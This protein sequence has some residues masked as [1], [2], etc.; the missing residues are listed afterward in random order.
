MPRE[1]DSRPPARFVGGHFALDFLNTAATPGGV[2]VEWL[3]N[4]AD[5]VEWMEQAGAIDVAVAAKFRAAEIRELD[6]VAEQARSLRAWLRGFV[7]R[8]AGRELRPDAA[9]EL[10]PLNRQLA[11]DDSYR[12]IEADGKADERK[13][14]PVRVRRWSAPEQ[15]LQPIVDAIADLVCHADFRRVR[16]CEGTDCTLI[17][18]DKTK[19]RVRRWCS[20]AACGNRAKVAAYRARASHPHRC[21]AASAR[22]GQIR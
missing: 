4:G 21:T 22:S 7:G 10:A 9:A 6:R 14:H 2:A 13:L 3:R 20:M 1:H 12:R 15:L 18:L 16:A 17:F 11:R 8:H 19:A 5:L